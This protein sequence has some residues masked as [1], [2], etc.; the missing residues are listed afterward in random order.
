MG[1]KVVKRS[2]YLN[3]DQYFMALALVAAKRS[4]DPATQT[5][6]VIVDRR[7]K[8]ISIG[9]NGFPTGC[10][11]DVFPWQ[12]TDDDLVDTINNKHYYVVHSELNAILNA[13]CDLT[14]TTMY[15]TLFPCNECAKA[16]IQAGIR[17]VIYGDIKQ[18]KDYTRAAKRMFD[19]AGVLYKMYK[20]GK[21][22]VRLML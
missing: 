15:A 7:N 4:K 16:I 19:S 17:T 20:Q 12:D 21:K 13:K 14:G 10:S 6:A 3:W 2:E 18:S 5:G 8:I 1:E 11:D 22:E 9:Y